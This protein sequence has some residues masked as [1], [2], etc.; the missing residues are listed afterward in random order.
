WNCGSPATWP[1]GTSCGS[2]ARPRLATSPRAITAGARW[3][4]RRPW[5]ATARTW[6]WRRNWRPR[7]RG[8]RVASVADLLLQ[9][10]PALLLVDGALVGEPRLEPVQA[11][12]LVRIAAVAVL[13]LVHALE[14][15]VDL[16]D[17]LAVAVAGAQ[18]Q[19]VLGFAGGAL[20]LVADV[21]HFV[22]EVLDGLL[23]FLDQIRTPL[24]QALAEVFELQRTHVLLVRAGTIILGQDRTAGGL[25][26]LVWHDLVLGLRRRRGRPGHDGNGD[27]AHRAR[28][29]R[30]THG[31]RRPGG[32]FLLLP[33]R[34][35]G[36]LGGRRLALL[37]DGRLRGGVLLPRRG[38]LG[39]L[40]RDGRGLGDRLGGLL[41]SLRGGSL[42]CGGLRRRCLRRLAGR[43]G[44]HL[45]LRRRRFL[46]GGLGRGLLLGG[47]LR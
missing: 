28:R 16:A 37:R 44:R 30:R 13:A 8:R 45:V 34:S 26:C 1:G 35:R 46:R 18:F 36:C 7:D 3:S 22:L 47:F 39:D 20:G 2:K 9:V 38:R 6:S 42:L 32:F 5:A 19:R 11:D 33:L 43:P 41:R 12:L 15:A 21:A 25:I 24:Q 29:K 27:L 17:Q 31:D 14:R 40:L 10:L 4:P 23:G